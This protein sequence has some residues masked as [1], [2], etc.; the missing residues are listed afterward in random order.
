MAIVYTWSNVYPTVINFNASLSLFCG[1]KINF[2]GNSW[3]VL[4]WSSRLS[5]WRTNHSGKSDVKWTGSITLLRESSGKW[6]ASDEWT[7]IV[8]KEWTFET[9]LESSNRVGGIGCNQRS[10]HLVATP[11]LYVSF[12]HVRYWSTQRSVLIAAC[13]L[14]L[15]LPPLATLFS[16]LS[17]CTARTKVQIRKSRWGWQKERSQRKESEEEEGEKAT[18]S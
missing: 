12:C 1:R 11:V 18:K 7:T 8:D 16:L 9:S 10:S 6:K 13:T 4:T 17:T 3:I 14:P 5:V 15:S 2:A